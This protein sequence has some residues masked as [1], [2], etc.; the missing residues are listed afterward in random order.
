LVNEGFKRSAV[1]NWLF[2]GGFLNNKNER[3][4]PA[5]VSNFRLAIEWME[6]AN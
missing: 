6:K 1:G 4:A 2:D 5:T 3:S